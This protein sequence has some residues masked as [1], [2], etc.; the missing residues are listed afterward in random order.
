MHLHCPTMQAG[1]RGEPLTK[2]SIITILIG[3]ESQPLLVLHKT[4]PC[5]MSQP[6]LTHGQCIANL[7]P[8]AMSQQ[9]SI[10]AQ[11]PRERLLV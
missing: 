4:A 7:C 11:I 10:T 2:K 3:G 8:E 9:L 1:R 5:S 6:V